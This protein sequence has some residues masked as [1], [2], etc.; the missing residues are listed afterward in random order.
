MTNCEGTHRYFVA[1]DGY[2][3]AE[4]KVCVVIVCT[5]CGESKLIEHIVSKQAQPFQPIKQKG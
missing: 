2:V 4:S 5:S 3:E 1:C